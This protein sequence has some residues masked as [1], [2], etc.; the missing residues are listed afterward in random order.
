MPE[1]ITKSE[2]D[3][4]IKSLQGQHIPQKNTNSKEFQQLEQLE[5]LTMGNITNIKSADKNIALQ[6]LHQLRDYLRDNYGDDFCRCAYN[7]FTATIT[8]THNAILDEYQKL[9]PDEKAKEDAI[10][11]LIDKNPLAKQLNIIVEEDWFNLLIN[12]DYPTTTISLVGV[13]LTRT[14]LRHKDF[15]KRLDLSHV[16]LQGANLIGANLQGA[17]L[18]DANLQ[19]AR[20][21]GA[22]LQGANLFGANLQGA[23]L[24][25]AKLQGAN[26]SRA[27]LQGANLSR[28]KLQGANLGGA[29]L[30]GADL[31]HAEL[32]GA[33]LSWAELQGANLYGAKLQGADLR[34]AKLQGANL[35]YAQLQ[36]VYCSEKY[37]GISFKERINEQV[38]KNGNLSGIKI[39]IEF[40]FDE[41]N[42]QYIINM[43]KKLPNKN[44]IDEAIKRIENETVL[45]DDNKKPQEI[46]ITE[47]SEKEKQDLGSYSQEDADKWLEEYNEAIK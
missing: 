37:E 4:K 36:G 40:E 46:T 18:S 42:K 30:Q 22:N 14:Y 17:R 8:S 13:N 41:N 33:N 3:K 43:L 35:S 28:A 44:Y 12:H 38:G 15:N 11:K 34:N 45:I 2:H 32:Q 31:R 25:G 23:N 20:L 47:L 10:A 16:N 27:E 39:K 5:Q 24:S 19:G 7:I 6:I 26:L 29:Q 21:I 1:N 9:V